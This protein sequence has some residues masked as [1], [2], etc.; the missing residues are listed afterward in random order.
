MGGGLAGLGL[1]CLLLQR[2]VSVTLHEAGTYP[3]HRLCGEFMRG[4]S[5][6][7]LELLGLSHAR[8][9][10]AGRRTISWWMR[11]EPILRLQ[12]PDPALA[13]IRPEIESRLRERFLHAGG[14]VLTGSRP[15]WKDGP[16][17][18]N[19]S[20]RRR[21]PASPWFGMKLH[22]LGLRLKDDLEMHLG[23]GG[24]V[25]LTQVAADRVNVSGLFR[26]PTPGLSGHPTG[27]QRMAHLLESSGLSWVADRL[28]Q[29]EGH[30]PVSVT[31]S[32]GIRFGW[33]DLH[34][35]VCA[36]GDA[37][38]FIP[39]FTGHGMALAL[40]GAV[41][42]A[43]PLTHYAEGRESWEHTTAKLWQ[44]VRSKFG[45]KVRAGCWLQNILGRAALHPVLFHAGKRDWLPAQRLLKW[46]S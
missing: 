44:D 16:G 19:A 31:S 27:L 18:V 22:V 8:I 12:L 1:A 42:A 21:H 40:E 37:R 7:S 32:A 36:V 29:A 28:T 3:K 38:V 30:D 10:G 17:K 20:G 25:G 11:G 33:S 13:L 43:G 23:P 15:D 4:L 35:D 45:R 46:I 14:A 26:G 41:M 6:A 5:P 9:T 34:R 2:G 24:Y 39:P